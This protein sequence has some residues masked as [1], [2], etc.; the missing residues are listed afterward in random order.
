MRTWIG[1][2]GFGAGAVAL[3][4]G[5][6]LGQTFSFPTR[7]IR[8]VVP[9]PAGGILD[10]VGRG[11]A[12]QMS[13][14]L[15]QRVIVDNRPGGGQNIGA[16]AVAKAAPDGHTML[17]CSM[18][19]FSTNR[20]L[21]RRLPYN[22]DSDLAALALVA[23][24]VET[25]L[26]PAAFP[27]R[28]LTDLVAEARAHPGRLNYASFGLGSDAHLAMELLQRQTGTRFEHV[29]FRGQADAFTAL[30]ANDVQVL[31]TAHGAA[32]PHIEGG[33]LRALAVL[34]T[35]RQATLP[36]VPTS[37][38][39]GFPDL[40]WNATFLTATTA[41]TPEPAQRALA[42]AVQRVVASAEFRER[43]LVPIGL[44]P[45]AGGMAEA[46]AAIIAARERSDRLVRDLGIALD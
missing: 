9:F 23:Q 42:E 5:P 6:A 11:L 17:L 8:M 37:A 21:Y 41:G 34:H 22:V 24:T 26:V 36:G 28:S 33:R 10:A 46:R 38:E 39:A 4:A 2:R 44:L 20:L 14:L 13:T 27:A 15:G 31:I 3:L 19:V 40:L 32:L 1:R 35:E 16:D 30:L 25:V 7:P 18:P 29:P 45:L 43:F 12:D